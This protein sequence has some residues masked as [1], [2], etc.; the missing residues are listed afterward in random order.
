MLGVRNCFWDCYPAP[1]DFR[2]GFGISLCITETEGDLLNGLFFFSSSLMR[3]RC[4]LDSLKAMELA[5][6][7]SLDIDDDAALTPSAGSG[8]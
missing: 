2:I 3:V 6:R 5:L 4:L 1:G 7:L 8:R